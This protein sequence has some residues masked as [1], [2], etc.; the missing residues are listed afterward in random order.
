VNATKLYG[1]SWSGSTFYHANIGVANMGPF[2]ASVSGNSVT[3][4]N[5]PS[6]VTVTGSMNAGD[7]IYSITVTGT[8]VTSPPASCASSLIKVYPPD[9][10]KQNPKDDVCQTSGTRPPWEEI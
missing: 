5:D 6:S 3:S 9:Y 8:P 7:P 1:I 2:S 4:A 10:C